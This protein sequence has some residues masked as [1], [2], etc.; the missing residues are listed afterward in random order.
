M[1]ALKSAQRLS[2]GVRVEWEDGVCANFTYVWLRDNGNRRPSLVHLD[3]DATPRNVDHN[4]NNLNLIWPPF[5]SSCY[6]SKFLRDHTSVKA[7]P[8]QKNLI[9]KRVL[10]KPWRFQDTPEKPDNSHMA[11]VSWGELATELGTVWPHFQRVPSII[12]VEARTP[13]AKVHLVDAVTCLEI[14]SHTNPEE[15]GFLVNTPLEY[16]QGFFNSSHNVAQVYDGQVMTSVFNNALRTAEITTASLDML[17]RSMKALSRICYQNLTTEVL[18]PGELLVV[19]NGQTYLGAPA[20]MGRQL[21]LKLY[22]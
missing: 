10:P 8:V 19:D 18:Q 11:T 22:N 17:Y 2:R 21:S 1:Y 4:E 3:L 12:G 16:Q 14:M 9:P 20:Q 13:N 5:L 15:F 7:P 6:S